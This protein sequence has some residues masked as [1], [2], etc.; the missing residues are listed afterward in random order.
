MS[1]TPS[2]HSC[3]LQERSSEQINLFMILQDLFQAGVFVPT[4]HR[5]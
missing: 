3:H 5:Q 1:A 4:G 2:K